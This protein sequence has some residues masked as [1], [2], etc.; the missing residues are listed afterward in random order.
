MFP[1]YLETI[2]RKNYKEEKQNK[3]RNKSEITNTATKPIVE[4]TGNVC[5]QT[6]PPK[7]E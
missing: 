6:T 7:Q 3:E 1:G 4:Q 5:P 2:I